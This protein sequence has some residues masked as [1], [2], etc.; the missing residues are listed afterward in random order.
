LRQELL[1]SASND[2]AWIE[3]QNLAVETQAV[4]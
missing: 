2:L 4:T 1:W 3:V